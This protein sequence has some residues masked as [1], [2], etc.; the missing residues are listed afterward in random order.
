MRPPP[1][2]FKELMECTLT[3]AVKT[4]ASNDILKTD[5][6]NWSSYNNVVLQGLLNRRLD[7]WE[8]FVY[9]DY[10]RTH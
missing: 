5:F 2:Y 4:G 9:G 7:E 8:M 1:S 6:S 10:V 3:N